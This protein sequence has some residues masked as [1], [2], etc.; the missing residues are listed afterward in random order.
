MPYFHWFLIT[1]AI[2]VERLAEFENFNYPFS[3]RYSD[4]LFVLSLSSKSHHPSKQFFVLQATCQLEF[5]PSCLDHFDARFLSSASFGFEDEG[6]NLLV[7]ITLDYTQ[8]RNA[9]ACIR[10]ACSSCF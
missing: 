6:R 10:E 7:I 1:I 8:I 3:F 4:L 2:E 9:G 5:R